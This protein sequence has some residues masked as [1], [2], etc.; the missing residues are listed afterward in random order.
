MARSDLKL[1]VCMVVVMFIA[2]NAP[3][4]ATAA[5][6]CNQVVS[7]LT[8]CISYVAN[9]GAVPQSCCNGIRTLY[10][11]AQ[12]TADRQTVCNCLKQ[13]VSQFPPYTGVNVGLATGLPA[14]CGINL[15]YKIS[16]STQCQKY[17]FIVLH[18]IYFSI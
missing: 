3:S 18:S 12:T 10:G 15:P 8:P 13:A 17:D 2:V 6:T 11:L 9:G 5:I 16:P 7:N 4:K 1:L 14:K